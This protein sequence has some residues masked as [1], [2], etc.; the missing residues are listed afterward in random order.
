MYCII[1]CRHRLNPHQQQWI[2]SLFTIPKKTAL[3]YPPSP[4]PPTYSHTNL[5]SRSRKA[6]DSF[7]FL[8]FFY[9]LKIKK[10][11]SP[12]TSFVRPPLKNR[13][14][15]LFSSCRQTPQP[16]NPTSNPGPTPHPAPRTPRVSLTTTIISSPPSS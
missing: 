13:S 14:H 16:T 6:F 5:P 10:K 9:N 11:N 12:H 4:P 2:V 1:S 3:T 15:L 8:N 7:F